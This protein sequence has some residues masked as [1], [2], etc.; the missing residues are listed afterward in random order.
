MTVKVGDC[1]V[2]H[3]F[4][5]LK[6]YSCTEFINNKQPFQNVTTQ[7]TTES[8]TPDSRIKSITLK[9]CIKQQIP[10]ICPESSNYRLSPWITSIY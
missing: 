8:E 5:S 4:N 10:S 1:L 2:I 9:I 7:D 3:N 6:F